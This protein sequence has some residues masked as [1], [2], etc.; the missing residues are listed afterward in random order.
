MGETEKR[1]AT[2]GVR[3]FSK[4]KMFLLALTCAY[5]SKS[6]SG[7]YMNSMLTQIERQFDIP[8]SIVGLINGSFEIDTNMKQR[9]HLQAT[10]P[11]TASC[12][13]KTEHRP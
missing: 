4:I 8:T 10:C 2:H 1:I 11:Q 6:L 9:F 3:C 13:W 12:V 7:I 5:V